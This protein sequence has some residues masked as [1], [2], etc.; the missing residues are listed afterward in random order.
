[1]TDRARMEQWVSAINCYIYDEVIRSYALRYV[2]PMLRG[3][4]PDRA[5]IDAAIPKL[6]RDLG[7]LDEA[8]ARGP[9]IAGETF[10]VADLLAAPLLET[11]S[12]FP[13]GKAALAKRRNLSRAFENLAARESFKTVHAGV[14]G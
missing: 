2:V 8:Y 14:F 10:S 6:E 1:H 7:L 11:V 13:E 4:E 5:A 12:M 3:T 9:W